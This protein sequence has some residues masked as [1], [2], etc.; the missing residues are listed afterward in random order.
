MHADILDTFPDSA[1][2][3]IWQWF[4]DLPAFVKR[5]M[6]RAEQD[7]AQFLE[8]FDDSFNVFV[9]DGDLLGFVTCEPKESGIYEVHLFCPRNTPDAKLSEAIAVF[10]EKVRYTPNVDKLIF[11]VRRRQ[12]KLANCLYNEGCIFT[13]WSYREHRELFDCLIWEKD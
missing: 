2:D 6:S 7:K 1:A 11:N 8:S 3:T 9:Y 4:Q 12:A 5:N 10:F 13:G